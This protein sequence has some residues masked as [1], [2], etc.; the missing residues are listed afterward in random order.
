[1]L[2]ASLVAGRASADL[3]TSG[4]A[5]GYACAATLAALQS[6]V[7]RAAMSPIPLG[8]PPRRAPGEDD[9]GER[10][11]HFDK[12]LRAFDEPQSPASESGT[13][14]GRRAAI[15]LDGP[16]GS[17]HY[18]DLVIA[19]V[20]DGRRVGAC[21]IT[22]TTGARNIGT[23]G[24]RRFDVWRRFAGDRLH[25]W[26]NVGVGAS[27]VESLLVP[28]VYRLTNGAL[29]LDGATTRAEIGRFGRAYDALARAP[30]DDFRALH[31]AA[32]A[33]YRAFAAGA[34]CP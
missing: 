6:E 24:M 4:D 32:A 10:C 2:A 16:Q 7:D 9:A 25:V 20:L 8:E 34:R 27:L 14:G 28:L 1:M 26:S 15:W 29:V 30:A 21:W 3:A 18:W 19:I 31:R 33:A 17:G 5:R 13:L 12:A 22:T 23:D 11:E